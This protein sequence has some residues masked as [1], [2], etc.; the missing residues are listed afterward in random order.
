MQQTETP[1]T[2]FIHL[3]T[4]DQII[5]QKQLKRDQELEAVK[6]LEQKE[7]GM[8]DQEA[9]A[10][11]VAIDAQKKVDELELAMQS[12]EDQIKQKKYQLE[13]LKNYK[14]YPPIKAE[15][16]QLLQSQHSK[17]DEVMQ[18]WHGLESAQKACADLQK[19]FASSYQ[20]IMQEMMQKKDQIALLDKEIQELIAQRPEKEQ[21]VP[22][23]WLEKY[24]VMRAQVED[25]VVPVEDKACSACY[26]TIP[27]QELSRLRRKAL[28]QCKGCY[29]LI[30]MPEA[31]A[32]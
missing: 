9:K 20:E 10:K 5:R 16:D 24:S 11:L 27:E 3:V 2:T 22:A 21:L 7:S 30:Y 12:L 25:P 14:E 13:S 6:A 26:T 28:L 23:E 15:L 1:F 29:R 31:M 17:E 18:T 32:N 4:F 8:H 19:Q